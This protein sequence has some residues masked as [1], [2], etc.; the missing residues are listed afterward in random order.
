LLPRLLLL[1]IGCCC[2]C[3][4]CCYCCRLCCYHRC[5]CCNYC[6]F[7]RC[8][9][10]CRRCCCWY[11]CRRR[12]CCCSCCFCCRCCYCCRLCCYHRCRCCSYCYFCR[13]CRF[14]VVVVVETEPTLRV[15]PLRLTSMTSLATSAI[16]YKSSKKILL[17]NGVDRN[18]LP[19]GKRG[20]MTLAMNCSMLLGFI[21]LIAVFMIGSLG[22]F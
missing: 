17:P 7:C 3:R 16:L 21:A 10:C 15:S 2:C 8:F 4:C 9:R 18:R 6:Y 1:L 12:C 14:V 11:C 5:R 19:K 22:C 20:T 13:C